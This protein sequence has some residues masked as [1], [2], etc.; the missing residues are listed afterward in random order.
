MRYGKIRSP[1]ESSLMLLGML[2]IG[3]AYAVVVRQTTGKAL[4]SVKEMSDASRL[5][6]LK[7]FLCDILFFPLLARLFSVWKEGKHAWKTRKHA[8]K[9]G[10]A[11]KAIDRCRDHWM[12]GRRS[13]ER[14]IVVLY[15]LLSLPSVR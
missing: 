12:N 2:S 14:S 11:W 4:G 10:H 1:G 8:W 13:L 6:S 15:I 9:K 3:A 7:S 5:L